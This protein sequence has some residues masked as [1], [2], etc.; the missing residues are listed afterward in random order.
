MQCTYNV[1]HVYVT[2]FA[3]TFPKTDAHLSFIFNIAKLIHT[4]TTY[5]TATVHLFVLLWLIFETYQIST[6]AWV[7]ISGSILLLGLADGQLETTTKLAGVIFVIYL[8]T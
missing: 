2:K 1:M 3:R 5:S 4:L 8:A 7:I 6:S